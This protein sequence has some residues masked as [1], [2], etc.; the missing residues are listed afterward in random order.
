MNICVARG[1][2]RQTGQQQLPFL[3]GEKLLLISVLV[4]VIFVIVQSIS[5]INSPYQID[6]GEGLMLD[7]ALRLQQGQPIYPDPHT[8]PVV[9][10]VYGPV[11]YAVV[12]SVLQ[13]GDASFPAGR[14]L[15]LLGSLALSLILASIVGRLSGC[16]WLGVVFGLIVLTLPAFR[17]W[18]Y[19]LRADVIGIVFSSTGIALYLLGEK[20]W[21]FSVPFFGI[22]V[23]CKYSLVAAPV[24]VFLHLIFNRRF[25][26]GVS[27]LAGLGFSC[28]CAFVALQLKT[29]GWFAFHMFS[30]HPDNYSILQ[31]LGLAA[32]VW[33]SAPVVT[34]FAIFYVVQDW[35]S[36]H[37]SFLT[38]YFAASAI[39]SLTAGKLGSTTN[40]FVEWMLASCMCAALGYSVLVRRYPRR[41]M[42]IRILLVVSILAG[43]FAQNRPSKQASRA[44]GECDRAYGDIRH[45]SS[46]RILAESLGPLL[47]AGKPV[48]LSDPFVYGQS[49]A[50]GKWPDHPI[51]QLIHDRY[52]D[53]IVMGDD[54]NLPEWR[55]SDIWSESQVRAIKLNYRSVDRFECRD[56]SVIL[57]PI[58]SNAR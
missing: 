36:R 30:T 44:L 54:P 33:I 13:R 22:A 37:R 21:Y 12:A 24:A 1:D 16:W 7:G 26:S 32:I 6:Y 42:Q 8:F 23:F 11:A 14:R 47:V 39:T 56:A 49:V 31:F 28:A 43:V 15:V 53:L 19:L 35:R 57:E 29:N 18:L 3:R 27:F 34:A 41:A 9:I 51:E 2:N 58:S 46:S 38:L 50:H 4:G 48:L 52:F 55:G 20:R 5:L 40:H 45:S 25:K 17:F 10:H